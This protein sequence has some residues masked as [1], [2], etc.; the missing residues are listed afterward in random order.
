MKRIKESTTE[1]EI[2]EDGKMKMNRSNNDRPRQGEERGIW[3]LRNEGVE[4]R[5]GTSRGTVRRTGGVQCGSCLGED[6]KSMHGGQS[7]TG[8]EGARC[9]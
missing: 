1:P 9:K 5:E 7:S 2:C 4:R 3:C 8:G 6:G